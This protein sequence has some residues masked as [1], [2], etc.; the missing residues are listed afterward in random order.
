MS[1]DLRGNWAQVICSQG[2]HGLT[3]GLCVILRATGRI[4]PEDAPSTHRGLLTPFFGSLGSSLGWKGQPKL[5]IQ[6]ADIYLC[7]IYVTL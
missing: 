2:A 6:T 4:C 1:L 7:L 5:N 3:S